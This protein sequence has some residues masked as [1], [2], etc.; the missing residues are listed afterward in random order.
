MP[1]QDKERG[2]PKP[3]SFFFAITQGENRYTNFP[4]IVELIGGSCYN[5]EKFGVVFVPDGGKRNG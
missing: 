5:R 2:R 3:A 1:K 4:N